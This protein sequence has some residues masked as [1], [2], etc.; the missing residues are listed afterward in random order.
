V[1]INQLRYFLT[2]AELGSFSHAAGRCYVSQPALS[3]Q[4]QKLEN[5]LGLLLFNR[6]RRKIVPTEAGRIL[7]G[8]A[9]RVLAQIEIAKREVRSAD[10]IRESKVAF[11]ILPT[12]APY[13]LPQILHTFRKQ[14]PKI[15]LII[16]EGMTFRLLELIEENKLDFA[17]V[18]LPIKEH[19]FEQEK[20]FTEEML[21][22]LPNHSP[23]CRKG[24]IRMEDLHSECFIL[25]HEGHCLGDQIIDF[26]NRHDFAPR[27]AFKGGHLAT[28]QS[29]VAAGLG[30][31]LVPRMALS[32]GPPGIQ[33][34]SVAGSH[35]RRSIA[36]VTR[37]KRPLKKAVQDLMEHLRHSAKKF[38]AAEQKAQPPSAPTWII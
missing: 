11:G 22:A 5:E 15:R 25:L 3:T 2:V 23:L 16:N 12:I 31:S 4:I 32:S 37:S 30:I 35:P 9:K 20:L 1:D 26:C 14:C 6:T 18:S 29:L 24:K 17:I 19:G 8:R 28:V 34:R 10:G 27:I 7:V 13:F 33:Y 21:L 38:K 36:I